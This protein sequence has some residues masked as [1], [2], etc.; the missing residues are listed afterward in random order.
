MRIIMMFLLRVFDL[1]SAETILTCGLQTLLHVTL[2]T[3]NKHK[4]T[5]KKNVISLHALT[6]LHNNIF[7]YT[8]VI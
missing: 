1:T 3:G 6:I 2:N 4:V 5:K 8:T 7:N